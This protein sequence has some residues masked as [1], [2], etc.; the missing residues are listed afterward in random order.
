[1]SITVEERM[2]R[3]ER[4]ANVVRSRLLRAVDALDLRRHQV[5]EL[6]QTAKRVAVPAA[7]SLV[8]VVAVVGLG[9]A[10]IVLIV[11]RRRSLASR[12]KHA[13]RGLELVH[14]EPSLGKRALE[15][16]VLTIIS[17]ASTELGRRTL[18]NF[19][20]GRFPSG[21][22]LLPA[23]RRAIEPV[24]AQPVAMFPA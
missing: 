21:R 12:V 4:R 10:A 7:L 6:G 2:N 17:V 3:L 19:V 24:A 13:I 15:K 14:H 16:A 1:M 22:R 9:A 20:D 18:R 8:G 5:V 23:E 11:R